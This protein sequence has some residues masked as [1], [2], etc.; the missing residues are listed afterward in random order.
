MSGSPGGRSYQG[1][2]PT[3]PPNVVNAYTHLHYHNQ[4]Y[5]QNTNYNAQNWQQQPPKGAPSS[6]LATR[7]SCFSFKSIFITVFI[8][9][10][11][12]AAVLVPLFLTGVF[13]QKKETTTIRRSTYDPVYYGNLHPYLYP[14]E[15]DDLGIVTDYDVIVVGA[16]LSGLATATELL[17][18]GLTVLVLEARV[19]IIGCFINIWYV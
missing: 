14:G 17:K 7:R 16:G 6:P 8:V 15:K 18:E 5:P 3:S 12:A 11:L 4:Q 9:I 1:S 2:G 19:R 10:L 13:K